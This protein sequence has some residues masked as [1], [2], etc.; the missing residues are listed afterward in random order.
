MSSWNDVLH[1][2]HDKAAEK[3]HFL[4]ELNMFIANKHV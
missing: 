2:K 3:L 1:N 4:S